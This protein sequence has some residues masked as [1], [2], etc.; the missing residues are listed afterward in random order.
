[1][2]LI[3]VRA[4]ISAVEWRE[5]KSQR[6]SYRHHT[7]PSWVCTPKGVEQSKWRR[8]AA[9]LMQ[10]RNFEIKTR[11]NKCVKIK[12]SLVASKPLGLSRS[13][14]LDRVVCVRLTV[15]SVTSSSHI[16]VHFSKSDRS[17]EKSTLRY[18][19][20]FVFEHLNVHRLIFGCPLKY[21]VARSICRCC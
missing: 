16:V 10:E 7:T 11:A 19:L 13:T 1:M 17:V 14:T 8:A 18:H 4:V 21:T 12:Q 9:L 6:T 3:S 5:H 15:Q 20:R 2:A